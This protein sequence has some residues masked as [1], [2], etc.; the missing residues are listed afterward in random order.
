MLRDTLWLFVCPVCK[1]R[2]EYDTLGNP[3]RD[4][5]KMIC[6]Q[7]LGRFDRVNLLVGKTYLLCSDDCIQIFL[8]APKETWS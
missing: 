1:Q 4:V 2:V 7:I 3:T 8:T 6:V 5:T